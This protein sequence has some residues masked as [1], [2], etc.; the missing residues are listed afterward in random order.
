[1]IQVLEQRLISRGTENAESIRKRM[2]TAASAID[3]SKLVL[4]KRLINIAVLK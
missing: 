4:L 3:Y 2:A 1:M